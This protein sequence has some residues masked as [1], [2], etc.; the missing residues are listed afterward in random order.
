MKKQTFGTMAITAL[1]LLGCGC[2]V[3]PDPVPNPN[4]NPLPEP[5]H[6][7]IIWGDN[8][9]F[10][11][12]NTP[13]AVRVVPSVA[14]H[15]SRLCSQIKER[16]NNSYSMSVEGNTPCDM[17]V[18]VH[19][20]FKVIVPLPQLRMYHNLEIGVATPTGEPLYSVWQHKSEVAE[21]YSSDDACRNALL[22]SAMRGVDNWMKNIFT[23]GGNQTFAVSIVRFRIAYYLV[24]LNFSRMETEQ[25]TLLNK[26]RKIK[27]VYDVRIIES[28][29]KNRIVSFRILYRKDQLPYGIASAVK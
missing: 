22:A 25:R 21:A 12:K 15:E 11:E 29:A 8:E 6:F 1:M 3:T 7:P 24:D 27:G 26:L 14:S 19:S 23:P 18:N 10:E 5:I 16:L 17:Q 28:N 4:P 20:E 13:L 2:A 9:L